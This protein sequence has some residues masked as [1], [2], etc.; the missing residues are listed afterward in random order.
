CHIPGAAAD[1]PGARDRKAPH[2]QAELLGPAPVSAGVDVAVDGVGKAFESGR[3]PALVDASLRLAAGEFAA[4]MGR[5]ASVKSTLLTLIGALER[6]D[7][8]TISVDGAALDT[9]EIGRA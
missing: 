1:L 4:L 9:L 6:P 7:T 8:G 3:I 2:D 5:S